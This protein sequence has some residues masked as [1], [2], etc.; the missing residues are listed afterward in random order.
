MDIPERRAM[1]IPPSPV[2]TN[3]SAPTRHPQIIE[4]IAP[5]MGEARRIIN[6]TA[7]DRT[8]IGIFP[9]SFDFFTKATIIPPVP[10]R[11]AEMKAL[12]MAVISPQSNGNITIP[13]FGRIVETRNIIPK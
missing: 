2:I 10:I 13:N 9:S 3:A 7:D 8:E 1:N 12:N 6:P 4:A 11:D 5:K